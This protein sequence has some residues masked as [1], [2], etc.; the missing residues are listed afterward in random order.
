MWFIYTVQGLMVAIEYRMQMTRS[1]N[2]YITQEEGVE[3]L[4]WEVAVCR[5]LRGLFFF[6]C[7]GVFF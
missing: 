6:F 7:L 1:S 4:D 5:V 2:T 3:T